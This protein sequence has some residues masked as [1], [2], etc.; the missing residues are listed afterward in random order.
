MKH[1]VDVFV[2]QRMRRRRWML[3]LTQP[4]LAAR[5]GITFQQIQKYEAGMN[6][7]SASRLWEI[8][9]AMDVNVTYFFDGLADGQTD[10]EGAADA[11]PAVAGE[12]REEAE[13]LRSYNAI[14]EEQRKRLFDLAKV[15]SAS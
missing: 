10:A 13:L 2:G 8:A 9:E 3:G 7:V 6:R 14:P 1:P 4:Q 15:L 11:E 12:S 5:V